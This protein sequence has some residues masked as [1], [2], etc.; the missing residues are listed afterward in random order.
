MST[1]INTNFTAEQELAKFGYKQELK[2]S[3]NVWELTAFGVNYM[4]PIAPAII[5]GFLVQ[6]S[7]GTVALPYLIAGIGMLFT[8]LA[9]STMVQNYPLAG[10]VYSYVGRATNPHIG[11]LSG[12]ILILDYIL[13]PTVTAMSASL[14]T[15]QFFPQIPYW[16]WLLLYAVSM[17]I[18]NLFGVELMAKLGI[19]MVIIGEFVVFT[20]FVVWGY[21][22]QVN[23]I[24]V[25]ALLSVEPFHFSSLSALA[26]ATSIAV[27]S[28]TGFDAITTLA[29]E[30]KNPRRDVPRA[31]YYSIGIGA[32]TMFL[33]GYLGM[34][35]IPN[36]QELI[37]QPGWVDTA[38]FQVSKLAGGTYF[39]AFYTIGYCLAMC[40]FNVVATA[41][42]AR[43]LYGMGRDNM[44]P[45]AIFGKINKRFNTPHWNI[46]LIVVLE[47][48]MGIGLTVA[49]I[50]NLINY[51]ALGGFICLNFGV[52]WL[53]YMKK[54]GISPLRL[55]YT[56]NWKPTGLYNFRY[57]ICPLL[58]VT[59]LVWVF[60]NLDKNALLVGTIWLV[61]G[62]IYEAVITK[63]WKKLP[64]KLD[65]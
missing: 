45:Q 29:E 47:Y 62:I 36:W 10:S 21:A 37:T 38:L 50:T 43:L 35:V 63:G 16:A 58:G 55:G 19:W 22:V 49:S 44:I 7:G 28:Y 54:K 26:G 53:Y 61:I 33:T 30:T 42:G 51:G 5:F 3:L 2:R 4:I 48:V 8:A 40:V 31:I 11:F 13:I 12:W 14:Y 64:P 46:I 57:F 25:G 60:S 15:M 65:L 1:E 9:Y 34:L 41:A 23:H 17:G 24:G 56:E 59:V 27:L 18:L 20:G 39:A 32:L 6:T 52:L